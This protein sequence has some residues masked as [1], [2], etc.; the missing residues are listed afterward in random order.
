VR[1][2]AYIAAPKKIS[3]LLEGD[4]LVHELEPNFYPNAQLQFNAN[5]TIIF[6]G[7]Y[8]RIIEVQQLNSDQ[9]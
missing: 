6:V 3:S 1:V 7:P 8:D 2:L 9:P 5:D 4:F